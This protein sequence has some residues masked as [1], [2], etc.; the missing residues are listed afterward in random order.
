MDKERELYNKFLNK[1]NKLL[2]NPDITDKEMR[3]ILNFLENNDIKANPETNQELQKLNE[4]FSTELPFD[5][6]ELPIERF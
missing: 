2:D 1:L 4:K 5:L 3:I 6:D